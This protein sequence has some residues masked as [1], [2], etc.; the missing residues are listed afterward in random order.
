MSQ[1]FSKTKNLKVQIHKKGNGK[2]EKN[3][4]GEE[5]K[6]IQWIGKELKAQAA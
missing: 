1:L 4:F 2:S 5:F 6:D 3:I